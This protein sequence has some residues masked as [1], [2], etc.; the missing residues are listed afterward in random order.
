[1]AADVD[2][3][4]HGRLV[5]GVGVGDNAG[6]FA[7]L[8]L[9]F[10]KLRDRQAALDE[11]LD[12]VDGLWTG[13]ALTYDGSHYR[14]EG[15]RLQ[16]LPVQ[17]PRI[18]VLI[19][20]GGERVTLRQV[21]RRADMA[22]FGAH[23]WT[24]GARTLDDIVRKYDV[25]RAHCEAA[26]RDYDSVGRSFFGGLILADTT[27]EA[28]AKRERAGADSGSTPAFSPADAVRHYRA[29]ADAGVQH[30]IVWIRPDDEETMR[31]LAQEVIPALRPP[32]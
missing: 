4:S 24:G 13:E 7:Q 9:P 2:Q 1:M 27:R 3:L 21:A 6:E 8:G 26:G 18:P 16:S 30:F 23:A 11:A 20:G 22:N 29:M 14:V 17:R 28:E 5:L 19:A 15:A 32:G 31:R 10:P 25:L 12:I